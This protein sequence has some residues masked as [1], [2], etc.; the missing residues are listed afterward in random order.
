MRKMHMGK[1]HQHRPKKDQKVHWRV[2]TIKEVAVG[3]TITWS[4]PGGGDDSDITIWFPPDP[5]WDP[6]GIGMVTIPAGKS[7]TRT[8]P[9]GVRKDHYHYSVFC[10]SDGKMAEGTNSPPEMVIE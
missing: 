2:D 6:L 1:P 3:D 9:E 10:H 7:I 4:T 5:R 8:V